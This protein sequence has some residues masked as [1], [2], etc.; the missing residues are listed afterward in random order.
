MDKL[1][2]PGT[3]L[4]SH[5]IAHIIS[6]F[7]KLKPLAFVRQNISGLD[8]FTCV[9]ADS[10]SPSGFMHPVTSLHAEFD[11]ELAVNLYS[12]WIVQLVSASFAWR[13][14]FYFMPIYLFFKMLHL[15]LLPILG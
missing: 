5:H 9:V 1:L 6:G 12:R 13:T 2:D 3:F 11:T 4:C 8:T 15:I 7:Q 10:L 14:H